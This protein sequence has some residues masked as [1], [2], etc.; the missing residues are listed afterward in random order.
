MSY[1]EIVEFFKHP[2]DDQIIIDALQ[3]QLYCNNYELMEQV[4]EEYVLGLN[5][6]EKT[7]LFNNISTYMTH[8]VSWSVLPPKTTFFRAKLLGFSANSR[9]DTRGWQGHHHLLHLNRSQGTSPMAL[10]FDPNNFYNKASEHEYK[11]SQCASWVD[12]YNFLLGLAIN[13]DAQRMMY[14]EEMLEYLCYDVWLVM[15]MGQG[16]DT[17]PHP[18]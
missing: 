17:S 18:W 2:I 10:V 6:T 3:E 1:S 11:M 4:L 13:T 9:T 7:T 15:L 12:H 16:V 14:Q 5:D 8:K